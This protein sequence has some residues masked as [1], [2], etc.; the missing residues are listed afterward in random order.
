MTDVE[1]RYLRG[2]LV[3][4]RGDLG[5]RRPD[6][7]DLLGVGLRRLWGIDT[8]QSAESIQ[9]IVFGE[10]EK[11][12]DGLPGTSAYTSNQAKT[13]ALVAYNIAPYEGI[14][15]KTLEDRRKWLGEPDERGH[16]WPDSDELNPKVGSADAVRRL[17]DNRIIPHL[18]KAF[19]A[20]WKQKFGSEPFPAYNQERLSISGSIPANAGDALDPRKG[21]I[22]ARPRAWRRRHWLI[23]AL[24]V[25]AVLVVVTTFVYLAQPTTPSLSQSAAVPPDGGLRAA[26]TDITDIGSG[27]SVVWPS[28]GDAGK[29][30]AYADSINAIFQGSGEVNSGLYQTALKQGAYGLGGVTIQ[31]QATATSNREVAIDTI[32][33]VIVKNEPVATGALVLYPG[34]ASDTDTI[35]YQLDHPNVTPKDGDPNGQPFFTTVHRKITL[36]TGSRAFVLKFKASARSFQFKIKIAYKLA[37]VTQQPRTVQAAAGGDLV[38]NATGDLCDLAGLPASQATQLRQAGYSHAFELN[39][40]SSD[41]LNAIVPV[42]PA[43]YIQQYCP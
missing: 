10:F 23:I 5:L 12:S 35:W 1:D 18:H 19:L 14:W 9:A 15:N 28:S 26:V 4:L 21:S 7:A 38:L 24:S 6:L 11:A 34:G 13:V 3:S 25:V 37:G 32:Y 31:L 39:P 27:F 36:Q 40:P 42:E 20:Q 29:A 41:Q 33:P 16:T 30:R 17:E 8:G 22:V 2:K 43:S